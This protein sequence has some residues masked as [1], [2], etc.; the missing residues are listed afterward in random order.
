MAIAEA[1]Q[2]GIP[3]SALSITGTITTLSS[4]WLATIPGRA[5]KISW[6][7]GTPGATPTSMTTQLQFSNDGGTTVGT[8]D[9]ST[10]TTGEIRTTECSVQLVRARI[11][12]LGA[13]TGSTLTVT[14]CALPL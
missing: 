7:V 10:S 6:I 13:T 1:L 11:T 14:V 2:C 5:N 9:I 8:L 3:V 4:N 12:S